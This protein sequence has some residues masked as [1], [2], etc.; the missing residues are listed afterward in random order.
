MRKLLHETNNKPPDDLAP[1]IKKCNDI[2][3]SVRNK[4]TS[5]RRCCSAQQKDLW[6]HVIPDMLDN[7]EREVCIKNQQMCIDCLNALNC[8]LCHMSQLGKMKD[9]KIFLKPKFEI[10]GDCYK[11]A[12]SRTPQLDAEDTKIMQEAA[13]RSKKR[14]ENLLPNSDSIL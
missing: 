2:Y 8:M 12:V 14:E 13:E 1:L 9:S 11:I 10:D 6:R 3:K 5:V 4:D 7:K